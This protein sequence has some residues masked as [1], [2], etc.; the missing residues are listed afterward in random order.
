MVYLATYAGWFANFE[1]TRKADRC[2]I[3][4][5]QP[6]TDASEGST[7]SGEGCVGLS[8]AGQ[9]LGGW[10][11]EQGE[12]FR[13]HRDLEAE[14]PYRAPAYTWALMIR[15]V[16]YYYES[17]PDGGAE[18][19]ETCAVSPGTVSEVLG[20]GNPAV[21]WMAL[22]GYPFLLFFAF[23]R[24]S[25]AALTIAL[26]LFGQTLPYLLSPRPVFLFYVT[27]AVP[28]IVLSL[29]YLVDRAMDSSTMKWVPAT[30]AFLSTAAFVFWAP[31]FLGFEVP[32]QFWDAMILF[33]SW[34]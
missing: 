26:F 3:Q 34:V 13:F 5:V 14:H 10:W 1:N 19:G 9:I 27:P 8:G 33:S 2:E 24:R 11:E 16:A 17:C 22:L 29:A 30:V 28:F 12:V 32:R 25:W 4:E 15:P 6:D 18:D 7:T 31:V 23:A 20:M 21:W